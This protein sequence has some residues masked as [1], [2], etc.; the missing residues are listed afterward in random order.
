MSLPPS[1]PQRSLVILDLKEAA[2]FLKCNPEVLRRNLDV[3]GVPHVRMDDTYYTA[4]WSLFD[5]TQRRLIKGSNHA[6]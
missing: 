6:R 1:T 3:W 4:I 5:S 2:A